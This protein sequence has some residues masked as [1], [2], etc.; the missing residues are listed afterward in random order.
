MT[1]DDRDLE[2]VRQESYA[3]VRLRATMDRWGCSAE[4]AQRYLDLREEGH[5]TYAASV[6]SGLADPYV[7]ED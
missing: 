5:S 3:S 4:D 2:R 1:T 7:E 6:M